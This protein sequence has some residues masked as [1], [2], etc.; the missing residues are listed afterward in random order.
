MHVKAMDSTSERRNSHRARRALTAV[1]M[2][3]TLKLYFMTTQHA[4]VPQAI[5]TGPPHG[6]EST[7]QTIPC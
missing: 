3:L 5:C 2:V 7:E 6:L 4:E 1:R